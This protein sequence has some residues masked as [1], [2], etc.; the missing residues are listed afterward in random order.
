MLRI[1]LLP[2]RKIK[3]QFFAKQQLKFFGLAA[4]ALLLVLLAYGWILFSKVDSLTAENKRLEARKE[5][6]AK[7]LKEI[8]ELEDKKKQIDGQTETI[9]KLAKTS[10]LTAHV[11]DAVANVTPNERMWLNN[12]D[13]SKGADENSKG[14]MKISGMALDNQTVAEYMQKL[15][16]S[17][18]ISDVTLTDSRLQNYSGRNLKAFSL[19]CS[20]SMNEKDGKPDD[21]AAAE[22]K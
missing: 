19:S 2:V 21:A 11:L 5:A 13:Q 18:Y 3:Q 1:N 14:T 16:D 10:A 8:K 4:G 20:V 12:I 22:K 9:K 15:E 7:I 17:P 6:L